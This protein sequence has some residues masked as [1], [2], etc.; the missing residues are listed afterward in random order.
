LLENRGIAFTYREYRSQPLTEKELRWLFG[1]LQARPKDLLRRR[2]RAFRELGL[3][4]NEDDDTLISL[5]H[6]HPTLLERPIGITA[7]RAIVGRPP[8]RLLELASP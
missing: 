4:G 5:M 3:S 2:D 1:T 6:E 7:D 8:E